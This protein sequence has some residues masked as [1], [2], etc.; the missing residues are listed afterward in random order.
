MQYGFSYNGIHCDD[1]HCTYVPKATK[2]WVLPSYDTVSSEVTERDGGYYYRTRQN[3]RT[4]SL[5]CFFENITE[6]QLRK[7]ARWQD[8][9][10]SGELIFDERPDVIYKVRP[11][12]QI[13]P[14]I[15]EHLLEG[16]EDRTY[17][18]TFTATFSAYEPFGFLTKKSYEA[19][20]NPNL[21]TSYS[22]MIRSD[23]MPTSPLNTDKRIL[24][25]NCGTEPCGAYISLRGS[26]PNGFTITNDTNGT[27]CKILGMPE[28]PLLLVID[29]E[30][31]RVLCGDGS[32]LGERYVITADG[33]ILLNEEGK[34]IYEQ[35]GPQGIDLD[36]KTAIR[37]FELH[38]D[39]YITL[40]PYGEVYRDV[41]THWGAGSNIVYIDWTKILPSETLVG[42]F[43]RLE[44]E[45]HKIVDELDDGGLVI[46]NT[47][48]DAGN[49]SS[50]IT[51]LNEL[52][53]EGDG[54][55]FEDIAVTYTP[56]VL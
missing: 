33:Y 12:K 29:S 6:H 11:S 31:C 36:P 5:D 39:G 45:W 9:K 18:G 49:E 20:E 25:Y 8:R 10:S 2:R 21:Y 56:K 4:F 52:I 47:L 22:G 32:F 16:N 19:D 17:S 23:E 24:L 26:A 46:M 54:F 28:S 51:T 43:I 13:E 1:M 34:I 41:P 42:K 14:E 44:N 15:Y 27:S 35:V 48:R 30:N 50:L 40:D 38:D 55:S 7:I 53:I 37:A 3:I